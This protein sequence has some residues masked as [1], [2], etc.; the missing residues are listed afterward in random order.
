MSFGNMTVPAESIIRAAEQNTVVAI[1]TV[2]VSLE[3]SVRC[4]PLTFIPEWL[5]KKRAG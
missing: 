1:Q 4:I 2:I 5:T 3:T